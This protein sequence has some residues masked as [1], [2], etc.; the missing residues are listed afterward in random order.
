MN[1]TPLTTVPARTTAIALPKSRRRLDDHEFL[2][3]ALEILETPPSPVRMALI[4]T[5]CL[6][7]VVALTWAYFGKIDI[8]ATAQGKVQPVGRVR[9]VQPLETGKISQI[10][11]TNGSQVAAGD[12]LIK[13]DP[14]EADAELHSSELGLASSRAEI[15]R[16]KVSV[17]VARAE[18]FDAIPQIPWPAD[19]PANLRER[20]NGVLT[21][22]LSKLQANVTTLEA[23]RLQKVAEHDQLVSTIATQ[24]KLIDTLQQRVDMRT[25][26]IRLNAGTKSSLIDATETLQYQITQAAMQE[27]QLASLNAGAAVFLQQEAKAREDFISENAQKI[28]DAE[29][30]VEDLGQ[31]LA[32]AQAKLSHMTL[33]APISGIVQASAA[34]NPGQV[35]TSGQEVMRI[36]PGEGGLEAEVYV[37]NRDIGFIK[38]GQDAV[39]KVEAFPFTRYGV[40]NAKVTQIA[41]DAIPEPDANQQEGDPVRSTHNAGLAGAQRTQNLVFSVKLRLASTSMEVDGRPLPLTSGMAITAD[42]QTGRRNLLEYLFSPVVEVGTQAMRER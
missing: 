23:Q 4:V 27:G 13:L 29:R 36:V 21:A 6:F 26:L 20:E 8:V 17:E 22:D 1:A 25:E 5:I 16:R 10:V 11:A 33:T 31:K 37:V 41:A 32:K 40:I 18:A 24:R 28:S 12:T 42:F 39:I 30:Q 34:T 15:A 2:A 7:V 3:P 9:I 38:V 14:A 19:V 35:L